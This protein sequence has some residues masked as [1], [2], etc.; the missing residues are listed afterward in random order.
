M[1]VTNDD[2]EYEQQISDNTCEFENQ[3]TIRE[4][5]KEKD[6]D[7]IE[8]E[9]QL[10]SFSVTDDAIN[11]L[12]PKYHQMVL[13]NFEVCHYTSKDEKSIRDKGKLYVSPI[14]KAGL[15]CI[16]CGGLNAG[17][18]GRYFQF[19][20]FRLFSRFRK[21]FSHLTKC[22]C[23]DKKIVMALEK[24]KILHQKKVKSLKKG[25]ILQ[26]YE[27]IVSRL[28]SFD[29]PSLAELYKSK[30]ATNPVHSDTCVLPDDKSLISD[31]TFMCFEQYFICHVTNT[32]GKT[33]TSK[34]IRDGHGGLCCRH[35]KGDFVVGSGKVFC[36][37]YDNFLDF[38][39]QKALCDHVRF[40][41]KVPE[42]I[43]K[44]AIEAKSC[45]SQQLNRLLKRGSPAK[46]YKKLWNRLNGDVDLPSNRVTR[47]GNDHIV[48]RIHADQDSIPVL[49]DDIRY[50]F[51]D[52]FT[53][54]FDNFEVCHYTSRDKS[55]ARIAGKL[56]IDP[57]GKAGVQCIHCGGEDFGKG[58]RYFR[59]TNQWQSHFDGF[60]NHLL[61]CEY[62]SDRIVKQLDKAKQYH[63]KQVKNSD[64]I[65]LGRGFELIAARISSFDKESLYELYKSKIATNP[66]HPDT[67]V[68]QKD[69]KLISSF[70][71]FCYQQ[72]YICHAKRKD[73]SNSKTKAV[74]IGY[75]GL[76]CR[77]C[78][79]E[80]IHGV[81]KYF[82]KNY[83]SFRSLAQRKSICDHVLYCPLIPDSVK[84]KANN[85]LLTHKEQQM[86]LSRLRK[87]FLFFETLWE[88][89]HG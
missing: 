60:H 21:M 83:A 31:Y 44:K 17:R 68:L 56:Y 14:G 49:D 12:L 66:V 76:S 88:R 51:S 33:S 15:Q 28:A 52:F 42:S 75:G 81:G 69:K 67:C 62:V 86:K 47:E 87:T 72:Y 6:N 16:H 84:K 5:E 70:T 54:M 35:C 39:T 78:K 10:R 77:Y 89:I 71:F 13:Q 34:E 65:S 38:N 24:E 53:M 3:A 26:A 11:S 45:H 48:E 41:P 9:D 59:A 79:G 8:V 85:A 32:D 36:K 46:F 40:C 1:H 61:K 19:Y 20:P 4:D 2:Y 82:G 55:D 58:G 57:I 63:R 74:H 80:F 22:K 37:D 29:R 30:N 64:T 73:C 27:L 23:I 18:G 25:S 50:F 7:M 43:K